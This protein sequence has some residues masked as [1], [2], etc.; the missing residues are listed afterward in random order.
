MAKGYSP[1]VEQKILTQLQRGVKSPH[2]IA[3]QARLNHSTVRVALSKM[4]ESG[5]VVRIRKGEYQLSDKD[6]T[7]RY[8]RRVGLAPVVQE[9]VIKAPVPWGAIVVILVAAI[10]VVWA[11]L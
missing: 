11:L 7:V 2:K 1:E 8:D 6:N 3:N 4:S 10:L 5:L 9:E